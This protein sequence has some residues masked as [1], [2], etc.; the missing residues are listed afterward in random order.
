LSFISIIST[1]YDVVSEVK[2][3]SALLYAAAISPNKKVIPIKFPR[4]L[5]NAI[6]E[7]INLY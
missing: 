4:L 6:S 7:T 1:Q 3:L 2:A 5:F